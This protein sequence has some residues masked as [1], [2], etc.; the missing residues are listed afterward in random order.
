[1]PKNIG[2]YLV[3][4]DTVVGPEWV[5]RVFGDIDNRIAGLE[6]QGDQVDRAIE[7]L[8]AFGLERID[9]AVLPAVQ[10]ANS[11]THLG[12]LLAAPSNTAVEIALGQKI[13]WIPEA[14]R[15]NFAPANYLSMI[16][17]ANAANYMAATLLSYDNDTGALIVD[18]TETGGSGIH[19]DWM[20]AVSVPPNTDHASKTDNPHSVTAAQTGAAT[21]ITTDTTYNVGSHA[22]DDF[23]DLNAA[24][25]FLADKV[26]RAG[27]TVT[28]ALRA[29]THNYTSAVT[30]DHPNG[31]QIKIVGAALNGAAL[32]SADFTVTGHSSTERATDNAAHLAVLNAKYATKLEFSGGG[33]TVKGAGLGKLENI[34]I[35]NI[36][37][38]VY[39]LNIEADISLAN[40]S[41]HGCTSTN[42]RASGT[43]DV[44]AIGSLTATASAAYGFILQYGC[45]CHGATSLIALG[46]SNQG[47]YLVHQATLVAANVY[48]R[49]NGSHGLDVYLGSYTYAI[50]SCDASNNTA[51]GVYCHWGGMV[52]ASGGTFNNNG[53]YGAYAVC[54]SRVLL[55]NGSANANGGHGL[56]ATF[57]SH[58]YAQ[59]FT[60]NDNGLSGIVSLHGSAAYVPYSTADGNGRHGFECYAAAHLDAHHSTSTNNFYEGFVAGMSGYISVLSCTSQNNGRHGLHAHANGY[61]YTLN[62]TVSG[63]AGSDYTPAKGTVGNQNAYIS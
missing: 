35:T 14:E 6:N 45:S 7:E 19:S 9:K 20:I 60:A 11:L 27:K 56:T 5:K 33:I 28:L 22:S 1:M 29:E 51:T 8:R 57:K 59:Y 47:I 31:Q 2:A 25:A 16:S 48:A 49:G 54:G 30:V 52:V 3:N 46:N 41:V 38:T 50:S 40:L 23:S 24:L 34:L 36:G 63:N 55:N 62:T 43:I 37:S 13:F 10:A 32:T 4:E 53:G 39:G 26:I 58:A 17:S 15:L 61:I 18:V 42:I 21:L 44:T 12:A